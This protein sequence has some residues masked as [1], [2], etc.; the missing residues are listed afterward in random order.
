[1]QPNPNFPPLQVL[2]SVRRDARTQYAL[3]YKYDTGTGAAQDY[4]RAMLKHDQDFDGNKFF[5]LT[6]KTT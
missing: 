5:R 3:G 4:A 6:E 2:L 1:M